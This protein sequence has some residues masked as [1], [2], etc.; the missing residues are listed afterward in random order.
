VTTKLPKTT[1][2]QTKSNRLKLNVIKS[3]I[4]AGRAR[5]LK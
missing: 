1:K 2:T 4:K 5:A 3:N